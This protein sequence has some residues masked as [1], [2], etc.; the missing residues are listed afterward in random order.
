MKQRE[1]ELRHLA[2]LERQDHI[3]Q[4]P[5]QIDYC[6]YD[7]TSHQKTMTVKK[8]DTIRHFIDEGRL[9]FQE[10]KGVSTDS[11]IFVKQDIIIPPNY[12]FYE[13]IE[14]VSKGNK[15]GPLATWTLD[16]MDR[17][18]L[19]MQVGQVMSLAKIVIREFYEKNKHLFPYKDWITLDD[20]LANLERERK[21]KEAEL[22]E[23]INFT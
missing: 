15:S 18:P 3:K 8:G 19:Q 23:G 21:R 14:E 12:T 22:N 7:G 16:E 1:E 17:K 11:V 6:Y 13:L 2:W 9:P 10:L 20:H 4:M 5:L